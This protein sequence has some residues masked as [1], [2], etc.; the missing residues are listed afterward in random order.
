MSYS[1][2]QRLQALFSGP[3]ESSQIDLDAEIDSLKRNETD[4]VQDHLFS[5][6]HAASIVDK[7][8]PVCM[9]FMSNQVGKMKTL[10][11]FETM[12]QHSLNG[13]ADLA[14]MMGMPQEMKQPMQMIMPLAKK[15]IIDMIKNTPIG[16]H[17]ALSLV[18]QCAPAAFDAT[19]GQLKKQ[20]ENLNTVHGWDQV[21]FV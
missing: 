13:I 21:S 18:L 14:N 8:D 11:D 9:D 6:V 2:L 7:N 17:P 20:H 15:G 16:S 4:Y 5:L 12:T 1:N 3:Q 19:I 10:G